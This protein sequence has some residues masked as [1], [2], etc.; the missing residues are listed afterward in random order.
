MRTYIAFCT[1]MLLI[2]YQ[3]ISIAQPTSTTITQPTSTSSTQPNPTLPGPTFRVSGRQ[4]FDPCGIP[5]VLKGVNRLSFFD[6]TDPMQTVSFREIAKTGA[7]C[8]RIV[9]QMKSN[10]AYNSASLTRLDQI[11]TNAKANGLIPIVG[12]W[13]YTNTD[14][15]GFSKL[16]DYV[17]YWTSP[18]VKAV[19]QKHQS[20]LIIN[21]A[22]EAARDSNSGGN[23]TNP[24]DQDEYAKAYNEAIRKIRQAGINVPLMIDGM[25]R[26]KSLLCFEAKGESILNADPR[27]NVIFSFHSYWPK[28]Y[29]DGKSS[30]ED[31]FSSVAA[32]PIVVV[33]GEL[34]GVGAS[35]GDGSQ[36]PCAS[37]G[38]QVDYQQFAQRATAAGMGWILWEWG[39]GAQW[40][41]PGDCP[42]INMTSNG[43]YSSL[44]LGTGNAWAKELALTAPYSIRNTAQHTYFLRSGFKTCPH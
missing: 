7:N 42:Q 33:I 5:I 34:A 19:I 44:G 32:H 1:L 27:R 11:I 9:W 18:A 31:A 14:D 6:A 40:Q 35:L 22:N 37:P 23:E 24:A 10:V 30:I 3:P 28:Q 25:D 29:T 8:V 2:V 43:L 36:N 20:A 15:G 26:G 16:P 13:D 12:L 41:T 38:G 21:I 39:P 17:A 4:L